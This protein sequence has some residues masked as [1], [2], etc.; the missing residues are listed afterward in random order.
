MRTLNLSHNQ[1]WVIDELW[2]IFLPELQ[3]LDLSDN[4]LPCGCPLHRFISHLAAGVKLF[5][6][7]ETESCIHDTTFPPCGNY[8]SCLRGPP[9]SALHYSLI[10][11]IPLSGE[12]CLTFCF[13]HGYSYYSRDGTQRCLCGSVTSEV[14]GSCLGIC[15]GD[16]DGDKCNKTVIQDFHPI[17]VAVSL[18]AQSHY[19]VFQTCGFRAEASSPVEKFVWDF[20]DGSDPVVTAGGVVIHKY[21]LPGRYRVKVKAEGQEPGSELL[22]TVM[23]PIDSAEL[24]CPEEAQTG[25][26]LEVWLRVKQGTNLRSVYGVRQQDG[27]DLIDESSCPRGGKIFPGDLHCYWLSH[28]RESLVSARGDCSSVP[29][30]DLAYITSLDQITFIQESFSGLLPVWVNVSLRQED[31]ISLAV[32]SSGFQTVED[33]CILLPLIPGKM[34]EKSSCMEKARSLCRCRAGV[35]LPDAPVFLV[36]VPVFDEAETEN[37]TLS[38]SHKDLENNIEVMVFPGLW[39]SHS[40]FPLSLEL[41]IQPLQHEYQARVQIL[42]PF[43]SPEEHLIPPGCVFQQSP[44]ATCHPH[45]LCNT[46]G[47]C[48]NGKQWCSLT[49]RCLSPDLPCSIYTSPS[50]MRPPRYV[51]TPPLYSPIADIPL[52]FPPS[53]KRQ[54]FQVLLSDL[55][56]PVYPDDILSIQHTGVKGSF[57]HC[58]YSS[59][60]FWRQSYITTTHVGWLRDSVLKDP[61]SWVDDVV[62]DLRILY[63]SE[64]NSLV[65]SPLLWGFQE[66]GTYTITAVLT[67]EVSSTKATCEVKILSPVTDV[68]VVHPT[69]YNDTLHLLTQEDNLVV[70]SVRGTSVLHVEWFTTLQSGE[71]IMQDECPPDIAPSLPICAAHSMDLRFSWMLLHF[72]SPQSNILSIQL[73]D[74]VG[75]QSVTVQ[76]QAHDAIQGLHIRTEGSDHIQLNQDRMFTAE[77]S[78]G[79]SVTFTWTID[80]NKDFSYKGATYTVTFRT[81]GVYNLKVVAEN[82][83]SSQEVAMMLHVE[84]VLPSLHA[85]LLVFPTLLLVAQTQELSLKI[86]PE[87]SSDVTISWNFGDGSPLLTRRL[88]PPYDLQNLQNLKESLITLNATERHMYTQPGNYQV[89]VMA[90]QGGSEVT[91]TAQLQVVSLLTSLTLEVDH[92]SLELHKASQFSALCLPS[93]FA[94]IFTWDF[95]D[96]SGA[97]E[98]RDQQISHVYKS[99]G[100]YKVTVIASNERSHVNESLMVTIEQMIDG[101]QVGSNGPAEMG[102][103]ITVFCSVTQGTNII[104]TFNMG[105]GITYSN[106]SGASVSH[107]YSQWG[108]F[109]VTVTARNSLNSIYK[110]LI[111]DIYRIQVTNVLPG[112]TTSLIST[113]FTAYLSMPSRLKILHWDFGDGSPS[114]KSEDMVDVWHTYSSTGNYTIKVSISGHTESGFFSK[115]ITVE[116]KISAITINTSPTASNVSQPVFFYA[117]VQ[118]QP[119]HQHH[120]WYQ[121]DFGQGSQPINTS[122]SVVTWSYMLE[123]DYNVTV[124]V[125]NQVS[126]QQAWSLVMV[127]KPIVSLAI[128][129]N[130]GT[131][132]PLGVE[133]MFTAKVRPEMMA[134]FTWTFGDSSPTC[135]GQN[136]THIFPESGNHTVSVYAKNR[137]SHHE[138]TYSLYV[139]ALIKD[140][141]LSPNAVIAKSSEPV[142]I[143]ATLSSGDD[144][145]YFWS[146]CESY[147]YLHGTSYL[148]HTFMYPGSYTVRVQANN[149]V[150]SADAYVMIDVQEQVQGVSIWQENAQVDWYVGIGETLTLTARVIKGSNLTFHWKLIPETLESQNSSITFHPLELGDLFVEVWVENA[151]GRVYAQTRVQVI[152]RISGVAIQNPISAVAIGIPLDLKVHIQSGTDMQY[153]WDPGEGAFIHTG[154]NRSVTLSYVT[155]GSKVISVTVSNALSS[156]SASTKL[157]VQESLSNISITFNGTDNITAVESHQ[158]VVLCGSAKRGTELMWEWSL[159]GM[160]SSFMYGAQNV[161]HIF[162]EPGKYEVALM[163]YNLVSKATISH[164]L[165]VQDTIT[166][167]KVNTGQSSVCTGQEVKFCPSVQRGTDVTFRLDVPQLNL[168]QVLHKPCGQFI[169]LFPGLYDIVSSAYNKVSHASYILHIKVLENIKGLK[170]L[171]IPSAWPEK[172]TMFLHAELESG[173]LPSFQWIFEQG[174]QPT[175]TQIG[176]RVEFTPLRLGTLHVVLN[177]SSHECFSL[178]QS[179][180]MVQAPVTS[181]SLQVSSEEVFLHQCAIFRAI[182]SDGSDLHFHW[183]FDDIRIEASESSIEHCFNDLGEFVTNVTVFNLVSMVNAYKIVSV[184]VLDCKEPVAWLVDPPSVIN[185]SNGGNFE[186][187]VNL[188]DCFKYKVLYQWRVYR[189]SDN[190]AMTLNPNIDTSSAILTI[191]GRSLAIGMYC[192]LFTV[193]LQGTPLSRNTT[194]IFEVTHSLLVAKIHGGSKLIWPEES[195]L[196]LDGSK[197]Y[198]PDQDDSEMK[199][200]WS[201]EPGDH[202]DPSCFLNS[203]PNLPKITIPRS[204]LCGNVSYSFTLTVWKPGRSQATARQTV[205]IHKG[206]VFPVYIRCISCDPAS[207]TSISN[208]IPVILDEEC[209]RCQKD[210]LFRWSAVD[211]HGNPLT[212]DKRT[213]TTGYA[214]RQ[215][216]IRKG[217]LQD[218][219]VYTFTLHVMQKM[220]PGW[221]EGSITLNP[222]QP[223]TGGQCSLHPQNTIVWQETPLEYH[224]TGWKDPDMDTQLFYLVSLHI[225]SSTSC[226]KLYLYRGLKSS[227]S[228]RVPAT[229]E[230]GHIQIWI[231]VEDMQGDR[232]L[233]INRSLSVEPLFLSR[234]VSVAQWLRNHSESMLEQMQVVG[235]SALLLQLALEVVSAMKMWGNQSGEEQKYRGYV[236]NRV[237][238]ALSSCNV[239]SVWEVA[240]FSAALVQCV[241][242]PPE[243]DRQVLHKVFYFTEK[244]IDMLKIKSNKGQR[245]ENDIPENLLTVLGGVMAAPYSDDLFFHAFTLTKD[246]TIILAKSHIDGE[247]PLSIHVPGVKIQASKVHPE[248]LLCSSSSWCQVS[249]LRALPDTL[250][251]H[252]E[253]IRLSIE[254]DNNLFPGGEPIPNISLTS[255]L[256]ALEFRSPQGDPV[257][258]KDLPEDNTI[259]LRMPVKKKV[260]L[261]PV[262]VVLAPK[263]YAGFTVTIEERTHRS[264]G[265][266]LYIVASIM[267][268]SDWSLEESSDLLITYGPINSSTAPDMWKSHVIKLSLGQDIA[269]NLSLLLPNEWSRPGSVLKYQVNITSLV[270]TVP[271]TVSISLF[272]SLCL[273]FDMASRMW[274]TDGVTPSNASRPHEAVCQTNHLTLF[275]ASVFVPPHQ[276]I[277]LPPAP[278]QWTLALMCCIGFLSLYVLLILISHKLDHLD[279]SR[280]GTIPLCGPAGQYRYWVLVKTGWRRGAGT[281]AHVGMCLYG[282]NKSGARHLHSRGGL[283]TGNLDMFQVETDGNLGEIWKIRVWHDNTGLDPSWFLQYVA[284]WDKQTDFLYFFVVNDWLAVDNERNGG[285]VEKEVLATCP[286]ELSSFSQ[287]F[288]A[289]LALGLTDW[290]LWLSV[291]WRPPRSRFTRIQRV[292]CCALMFH[293]YMTACSLWYGAAGVQG[294]SVPLGSQSLVS[295]HSVCVG[296]LTSVMVLPLQ[297]LFSFL[298]RETRSLVFVEDSVSSVSATEEKEDVELSSSS[299]IL[300]IPGGADSLA[301]ISSLSCRSITSSKFTFDLAKDEF[302]HL[303]SSAPIWMSSCDSL[304][305]VRHDIPL[306]SGLSVTQ[307]LCKE[308]RSRGIQSACSSGDDPL[309]LSEGSS[310]SPQ[311]T[312]SEGNVFKSFAGGTQ[313]WK[314][315]ESDSGRFSPRP[316]LRS[317]STESGYSHMSGYTHTHVTGCWSVDDHFVPRRESFSSSSVSD[318][319]SDDSELQECWDISSASPSPFNTRIGVRWKPLGWLFPSWVLWVVYGVTL[320]MIAGCVVV[321][322]LYTSSLMER[323]FL[324][325]LIS[326]TCAVLTSAVLLEPLRVVLL[327]LYYSLRCP[328]VLSEALG[329]VEEPL[330]KKISDQSNKVR[331]PGGFSLLQAKEEA[332]RVRTL[333]TMIRSCTGYMIFLL[334]VLM[335]NFHSTSHDTNIRLLHSAIKRSINSFGFT[336]IHSVSDLWHWLDSALPAHLYNDPRLTLVGSP[337]LCQYESGLF[338]TFQSESSKIFSTSYHLSSSEYSEFCTNLTLRPED[339]HD[340]LSIVEVELTQYHRDVHLHISTILQLDLSSHGMEISRLTILPFH[341]AEVQYGLNLPMALASSLLLAA[342]CFLYLELVAIKD[343]FTT[344]PSY[345]PDWMQL[346]MGLSSAATGVV[347]FVRIWLTKHRMDQYH[348]K[349]W[350]F[351]SLHDVAM[352]S[353]IQVALSA[354]LLFLIMLKASQQ[355]R[356]VRRWAIFGKIFVKLKRGLLGCLC[357]IGIV[358]FALIHCVSVVFYVDGPTVFLHTLRHGYGLRFLLQ[359]LPLVGL[360]R[361][362]ALFV[363]CRG[364]LFGLVL[365][366]HRSIR[367]ENYRP[368]L[369]PQ[370]HEMIDFLVKRFKL[371]LGVSKVKEYR[372]TVRFE[373]LDPQSKKSSPV[374]FHCRSMELLSKRTSSLQHED[375]VSPTSP[376]PLVSPGLAI[377]HLP[378]A[379]TE[380][381]ERMDKVTS[382]LIEVGILE[383]KLKLWQTMQKASKVPH[384]DIVVVPDNPKQ[385]SL[386]RTYSTYSESAVTRL[387]Y[388]RPMSDNYWMLRRANLERGASRVHPASAG[389]SNKTLRSMRRPHSEEKSGVRK[390][391]ELVI[392]PVPQKRRAWDCEKPE[393]EV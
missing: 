228:V 90:Y 382:L 165:L 210:T 301:D 80:N 156:A 250:Q 389:T 370:D 183:V 175:L 95:G 335:M 52:S 22:T 171:D 309:S 44:F 272:S 157:I 225:C 320:L 88:S 70:I 140:L 393:D 310:Y 198:D 298:F 193:T 390:W 265:V 223:P 307:P 154:Q 233:A 349:P 325:W 151:L 305:D 124:T 45:P 137:V 178:T 232:T 118:P 385:P 110:S 295:W 304:Y 243:L 10:T 275:G 387:K 101:L 372:H 166:G 185:R 61:I 18:S 120:Y 271:V 296:F 300:S 348:A 314:S 293:L 143:Y 254:L 69:P 189:R 132:I 150:S 83:V 114:I 24:Q 331:A 291:W 338:P 215:L 97:V 362:L 203:F 379:V 78:H 289:Q 40:G 286:Q 330:V 123:G 237:T 226:Q 290:H 214:Q 357:F 285:R 355:L 352:L 121:W 280:V 367:A 26:S 155:Q 67:N 334:L 82:P 195:D 208:R 253:L 104:W 386:P 152:E 251:D 180:V 259:T 361:G 218:N 36:G 366:V 35:P 292:T 220:G 247:D 236:H 34:Y 356:F 57:L 93:A 319:T 72:D 125:W 199:Y 146:V 3:I 168:S 92:S 13:R 8:V 96:E 278:R 282:V 136:V 68:Q 106:Q 315:S 345:S 81:P 342:M 75:D 363:V 173:H 1:I 241:D 324:L 115:V 15:S 244:M 313:G 127:Q 204:E 383:Q 54:N 276:L 107:I 343:L 32:S 200:D 255:Q 79:S 14:G 364:L 266:H 373:G 231:E 224:C 153:T 131:I 129:H 76:V 216:I 190:Q 260:G 229:V 186:A 42:R 219:L 142:N 126:R 108:N 164:V 384:K 170:I 312:C 58:T 329:L 227:N 287:V 267:N 130:G 270:T 167:F 257:A 33:G 172:K 135:F 240:A 235:D 176:Q 64:E 2:N 84:G 378:T 377:E 238:D 333:K 358:S 138:A 207:P 264:A 242:R 47:V 202:E 299:S 317:P 392:R 201:V 74:E 191:P 248:K 174:D 258:I 160:N 283:T 181:V 192:L 256:V 212:L 41:G 56:H 159:L 9:D 177:V 144:V 261:S 337:R 149:S 63:G 269:Q 38:P 327:S 311:V 102:T 322:L 46:T 43:C 50:Y 281:T 239:S 279:V 196:T 381:L 23:V 249:K 388:K 169:F 11:P 21:S 71:S 318:E 29:G 73:T 162:E 87:R 188:R 65:V 51:G 302:W 323:G 359:R 4:R 39:F 316:D 116:D 119:D 374:S 12:A 30:G 351:I 77:V 148:S 62:C 31:R 49:D 163:V 347:H 16:V 391:S 94:V 66:A 86:T 209:G 105:D 48:P 211:S 353:R 145:Q 303:E 252:H 6:D 99:V 306:E 187:V 360:C 341:L 112:I 28:V 230:A 365:N 111:V 344:N 184:K 206:S 217:V 332:R 263:G 182:V 5:V 326:C 375:L 109:T 284:V 380:L 59:D 245:V 371:W 117:A 213:T 294:E 100:T 368:A 98:N 147:P 128:E 133:Q 277:L 89:Q 369:E 354:S 113:K 350:T 308:K 273:Y 234:G 60:S 268:G 194:H 340:F 7:P 141:S 339:P 328:P 27:H 122:S 321:T 85:E 91:C 262:T 221:G 346:V 53:S 336:T 197:S 158:I 297:L 274:R 55:S 246:F 134:Q 139:Q 17:Q 161:S 103:E 25:E 37:F 205:L 19:S 222:N 288:P 376:R 20:K 179:L